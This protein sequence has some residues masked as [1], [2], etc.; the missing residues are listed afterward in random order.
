MKVTKRLQVFINKDVVL[1]LRKYMDSEFGPGSRNIS[2][3]LQGILISFLRGKGYWDGNSDKGHSSQE[4]E[5]DVNK[6]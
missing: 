6:E 1:A 4:V 5:N 3:V 2:S